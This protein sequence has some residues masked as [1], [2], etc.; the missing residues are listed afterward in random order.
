MPG[1]RFDVLVDLAAP[2]RDLASVDLWE[3]SLYRSRQR[4]RLAEVG[5]K[6]R[7]RRKS[8]SLA[9]TAALAAV[10][11]IPQTLAAA[12][13]P[14]STPSAVGAVDGNSAT[15]MA[16]AQRV[17][18]QEGSQGALVSALQ[19]RLDEVLPVTHIAVDGIFGPQTRGAVI[20]FQRREGLPASGTVDTR[21]W[22]ALFQAPVLVFGGMDTGGAGSNAS[23]PSSRANG[24]HAAAVAH[25]SHASRTPATGGRHTGSRTVPSL[26]S[27][28]LG[29]PPT[30]NDA[31]G[32]PAD[33][34]ATPVAT[35][36]SS[37]GAPSNNSG[38]STPSTPS[39]SSNANHGN[40]GAPPVA[41]V[42]PSSPPQQ[43][44]TYVLTNGVALPLPRQYVTGGFVDS[45]V[46]YAAPGGTPEY[47]MGDGVIIGEGI[48]GFGPNAPILRITDGPL[49]GMEVY[50]GHA[51]PDLVRVGQ[52]VH[53]G[54]QITIVGYGIVGI[55]TGPHLEVGF[56]P[57]NGTGSRM[58]SVI[59]AILR[60]HPT[61]RAWGTGG[62]VLARTTRRRARTAHASRT[63]LPNYG[64]TGGG[65]NGGTSVVTSSAPAVVT[66]ST[67]APVP[68]APSVAP[69][70]APD[71]A[72]LAKSGP[73]SPAPAVASS[74][75]G[76]VDSGEATPAAPAPADA[77]TDGVKDAPP[78][79]SV[80]SAPATTSA[81][82][83]DGNSSATPAGVSGAKT[84]PTAGGPVQTVT[85][86]KEAVPQSGPVSGSTGSASSATPAGTAGTAPTSAVTA[87]SHAGAAAADTTAAPSKS[88]VAPA[89]AGPAR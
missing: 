72:E 8:A 38:P 40:S 35:G 9:T 82:T 59:N 66:A 11:V 41:V 24:S 15:L 31:A 62:Q 36:P 47:A 21:S 52:H 28:Q 85:G 42:A 55:S 45:G 16:A 23:A 30:A 25:V 12:E 49:K 7:R 81:P 17:V 58:L 22:A 63:Y 53:A 76:V 77:A 32:Q 64:G 3:R 88:A 10:P 78:V 67:P 68:A 73:A 79:D 56:Y 80:Q 37:A 60:Q 84:T 27:R 26:R 61:G 48:S 51:G 34:S 50:Y 69:A 71:T 86:S 33:S 65:G 54:Q 57:P 89:P 20:E 44:S 5:R 4:R 29:G 6:S 1:V 19:T 83:A 70:A 43:T 75:P 74:S 14:G 2:E 46:D 39:G 18:L 13:V 87:T